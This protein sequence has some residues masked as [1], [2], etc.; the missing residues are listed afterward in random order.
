MIGRT[1]TNH[2]SNVLKLHQKTRFDA[3]IVV[4]IERR[5]QVAISRVNDRSAEANEHKAEDVV[6]FRNCL[7]TMSKDVP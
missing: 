7:E 1:I 5:R 4:I 3:L 6:M 2:L